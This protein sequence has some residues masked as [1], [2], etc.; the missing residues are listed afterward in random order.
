MEDHFYSVPGKAKFEIARPGYALN[1]PVNKSGPVNGENG[2]F[3]GLR[4]AN[5]PNHDG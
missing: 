1:Q 3:E 4:K 5:E 2:E